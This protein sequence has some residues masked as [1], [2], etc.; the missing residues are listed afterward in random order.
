MRRWSPAASAEPASAESVSAA[1]RMRRGRRRRA[2][3]SGRTAGAAG[4]SRTAAAA[5]AGPAGRLAGRRLGWPVAVVR[6]RGRADR[7]GGPRGLDGRAGGEGRLAG[8][9]GT[10]RTLAKR[11]ISGASVVGHAGIVRLGG[12]GCIISKRTSST[13]GYLGLSVGPGSRQPGVLHTKK[14]DLRWRQQ[15]TSS[16]HGRT[17]ICSSLNLCFTGED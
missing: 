17:D 8:A 5:A 1:R 4:A 11:H 9:H 3:R 12:L 10:R 13:Q 15:A 16:F 14:P 7:A 6:R 2:R